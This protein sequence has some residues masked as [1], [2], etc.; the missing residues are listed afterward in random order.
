LS[1]TKTERKAAEYRGVPHRAAIVAGGFV[2]VPRRTL[3][4]RTHAWQTDLLQSR[5]LRLQTETLLRLLHENDATYELGENGHVADFNAR[6]ARGRGAQ[7][8]DH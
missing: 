1:R 5:R 2:L 8:K 3:P 6:H 4:H 7:A